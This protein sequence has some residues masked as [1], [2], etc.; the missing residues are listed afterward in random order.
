MTKALL[1][2]SSAITALWAAPALG[3]TSSAP[4]ARG[5][6]APA[7]N[8]ASGSATIPE[9]VVTAQRRAENLQKSSMSIEVYSGPALEAVTKAQDLTNL[10]PGVVVG[11]RGSSPQVFI[12]GVGDTPTANTGIGAVAFNV[13]GIYYARQSSVGPSMFD[14][15][16]IEILKGPQGTLYG[17][18]ATG[19]AVNILTKR[20]T[21][22]SL[23]GYVSGEIGNFS[24]K[25]EEAAI[26]LPLGDTAALRLAGQ[27][28]DRDGYLSS[29]LDDE[30]SRAV[31][32]RLLFQ[33]SDRY[34]FLLNGDASEVRGSGGGFAIYPAVNGDPWRGSTAQPL[35]FPYQFNAA[36]A[37]LT[38]PNDSHI[39]AKNYGVSLEAN[40]DLGFA[41]LTF[42]PAYRYQKLLAVQYSTTSRF[43]ENPVTAES[44]VELRLGHDSGALKWV[45]GGYYYGEIVKDPGSA[46]QGALTGTTT[47][48]NRQ[49]YAGFAQATYSLTDKLRLIGGVRYTSEK[50][51]G[52]YT[53][54]IGAVN[55]PS[56]PYTEVGAATQVT[57]I[58]DTRTNYKVG[59]E[60]DVSDTSMLYITQ[61]TGFKAGGF[62]T[63]QGCASIAYLPE[64]LEALTGGARN[65]FLDN[66]LQVN[67]EAFRWIYKNQQVTFTAANPCGKT[68]QIT[69]NPGDATIQGGNLD[70]IFQLT[71]SDTLHAGAEYADSRYDRY[72]TT[73]LGLGPYAP[74]L[75]SACRE[76]SAATAGFFNIDCTGEELSRTPKWTG[77]ASYEHVFTLGDNKLAFSA[78]GQFASARWLDLGYGPNARAPG[79]AQLNSQ[80]T[81]V[82]NRGWTLGVFVNNITN[83]AVYTGGL[84][85]SAL[86]PNGRNFYVAAIEPPR[87]FG[88]R[89]RINF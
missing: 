4:A 31:R 46:T 86:A 11:N 60:Y 43:A 84:N 64:D 79:Y 48:S 49:A 26:N 3:Q 82:S 28:T 16:R 63:G 19:G 67:A 74:G 5:E 77:T 10:S 70:V 80:L 2:V 59:A 8:A 41:T 23:Q 15:D 73:Q 87:T 32:A 38:Q 13:D 61:S 65:R 20:P 83:V 81:Y 18:N 27:V 53:A 21:L 57:P 58:D 44:S 75:G 30:H 22:D 71:S 36:T 33:P 50:I 45:A 72:K 35:L 42:I 47:D 14:I 54:A 89:L 68:G 69:S 56:H 7:P 55:V 76:S 6:A 34:S 9:I 1:L 66:R 24:L 37:P 62:T 85:L 29:G 52:S 88:A 39:D 12:R 25:R 17:R 51:T 78:T 40:I